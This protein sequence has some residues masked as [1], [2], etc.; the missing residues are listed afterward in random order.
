MKENE[1][2]RGREGSGGAESNTSD[3]T[4][5]PT[6]SSNSRESGSATSQREKLTE[7]SSQESHNS[8]ENLS[9]CVCV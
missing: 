3:V 9:V 8:Q 7:S 6:L 5:D 4:S 1:N 2:T